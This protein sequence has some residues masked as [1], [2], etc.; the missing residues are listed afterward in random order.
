MNSFLR[1]NKFISIE[2]LAQA[3]RNRLGHVSAGKSFD[4][5]SL[6]LLQIIEELGLIERS[7]F[8]VNQ[9]FFDQYPDVPF[10]SEII[11]IDEDVELEDCLR[12]NR[13]S[14]NIVKFVFDIKRYGIKNNIGMKGEN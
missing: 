5:T 12:F 11:A 13:E 2:R 3:Y 10:V 8:S 1:R 14:E 7:P 6:D 4:P 9:S